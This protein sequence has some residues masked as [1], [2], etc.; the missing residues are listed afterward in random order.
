MPVELCTVQ[1]VEQAT[2][3]DLT[4]WTEERVTH[5][6]RAASAAALKYTG[7]AWTDQDVP[8]D[9]RE[10]VV[11]TVVRWL[12]ASPSGTR[13]DDEIGDPGYATA[14]SARARM[15]LKPHVKASILASAHGLDEVP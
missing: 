11:D 14:L 9:A 6:I 12:A 5:M 8:D 13:P 10:A 1:E 15:L 2:A 7:R 3:A 4:S